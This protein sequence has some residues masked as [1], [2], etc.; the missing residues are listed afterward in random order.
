MRAE[1]E[2]CIKGKKGEHFIACQD[3]TGANDR[4]N[5]SIYIIYY[6]IL[7]DII[8]YYNLFYIL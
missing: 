5:R 3:Y 1:R 2:E 4:S 7:F 6:Y 8:Y